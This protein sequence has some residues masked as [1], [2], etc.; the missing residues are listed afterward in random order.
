MDWSLD[1]P[2]LT[3]GF[4][5]EKIAD[6]L[7][8]L[9]VHLY[10]EKG[11]V[12]EALEDA[13]GLRGRQAGG[14]RGDVPAEVLGRGVRDSSSR[15]SKKHAA[16]W[17]GFY[18]GKPPEELSRSKTIADALT[19]GWLE[20]FRKGCRIGRPQYSGQELRGEVAV[21]VG[22]PE[23]AA[24]ELVRQPGMVEAQEVEHRGLEVVHVHLVFRHVDRLD[25][26]E[27]VDDLRQVG[28]HLR[29][30]GARLAVAGELE[31]RRHQAGVGPDEG[32]PLVLD[33]LGRDRLAVV[34]AECGLE[35]EEV[36]LVGAPAMKRKIPASLWGRNAAAWG[37]RVGGFGRADD[38]V[39]ARVC[40]PALR[41]DQQRR[42]GDLADPHAAV[43]EEVAAGLGEEARGSVWGEGCDS[44]SHRAPRSGHMSDRAGRNGEK[45]RGW[46]YA[47]TKV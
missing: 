8:F 24:L 4:V 1:R 32:I 2:G 19:L 23:L 30:L 38:A 17:I 6:D 39:A 22:Q 28:Q 21:H 44:S 33:D 40:S 41:P 18:W 20:F 42:Q 3:S 25:D 31:L 10:P 9:C 16:G 29:D 14:D 26:G 15:R 45:S 27:L 43:A 47:R 5:P 7:D 35:V 12:D 11:K 34:L 13:R 36:E 37:E 46:G